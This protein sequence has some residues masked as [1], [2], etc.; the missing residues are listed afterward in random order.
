MRKK[1]SSKPQSNRDFQQIGSGSG[2]IDIDLGH[3]QAANDSPQY[4]NGLSLSCP[5]NEDELSSSPKGA[6]ILLF[7]V[8]LREKVGRVM[9]SEIVE[10]II[11]TIIMINAITM[12]LST[13]DF[14]SNN[15]EIKQI[16]SITD[17]VFTI[18]F[19]VES[20]LR[21]FY[22]GCRFFKDGWVVFD[23]ILVAIS[24]IPASGGVKALR[25]L[26][27]LRVL[28]KV[29][30]LKE[31]ISSIIV[32]LPKM[33]AVAL[34]LLLIMFIFSILFTELF[35]YGANCSQSCCNFFTTVF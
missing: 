35:G 7:S 1:R 12:G 9:E 13:F 19:T 21:L 15:E 4:G 33:G 18:I 17:T 27:I 34:L 28:T 14:V 31:V 20:A 32:V 2:S 25:T 30:M 8:F 5:Q 26:R 22:M 16:F 10:G 29:Q 24:W 23:F 11:L 3:L 6:P